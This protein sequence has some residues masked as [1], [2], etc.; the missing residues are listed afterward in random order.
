MQNDD[1][2]GQYNPHFRRWMKRTNKI[3]EY[4]LGVSTSDLEGRYNWPM[5][6]ESQFS[7][8]QAAYLAINKEMTI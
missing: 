3:I 8:K 1:D 7:P 5:L 4:I 6:F 2:Y